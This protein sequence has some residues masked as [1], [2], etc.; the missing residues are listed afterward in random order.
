MGLSGLI[1]ARVLP[2]DWVALMPG[3]GRPRWLEMSAVLLLP[4]LLDA[5]M[6]PGRLGP[7]ETLLATGAVT[8]WAD[9]IG[10]ASAARDRDRGLTSTRAMGR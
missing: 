9:W 8:P 3:T 10:T 6:D 4:L 5:G 7:P 2:L 1:S